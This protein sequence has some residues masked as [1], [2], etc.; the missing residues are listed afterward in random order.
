MKGNKVIKGIGI[1]L[2]GAA[3]IFGITYIVMLLWNAILPELIHVNHI[4]YWQSMGLLVLCKILFG[5]MKFNGQ[6]PGRNKMREKFMN[7]SDEE[8]EAFK[9]RMKERCEK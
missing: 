4:G 2:M 7:M 9:Q 5:G 6:K 1:A 3:A 8:R